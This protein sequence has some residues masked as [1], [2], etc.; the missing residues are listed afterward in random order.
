MTLG[1]TPQTWWRTAS[2][3]PQDTSQ[4]C[5]WGILPCCLQ[6]SAPQRK[7]LYCNVKD[8][9][10]RWICTEK[11]PAMG[12]GINLTMNERDTSKMDFFSVASCSTSVASQCCLLFRL[13]G[14]KRKGHKQ[15]GFVF[16]G[17]S[18]DFDGSN[19]HYSNTSPL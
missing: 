4:P 14:N 12:R 6:T 9:K 15:T 3:K 2:C 19:F 16:Q 13:S 7:P 1:S 18:Y 8:V 17:H 10:R 11:V 5:T